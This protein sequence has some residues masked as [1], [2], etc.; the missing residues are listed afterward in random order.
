ALGF[1]AFGQFAILLVFGPRHAMSDGSLA[2]LAIIAFLRIARTEPH[3]SQLLQTQQTAHLA[4]ANQ[5]PAIG[6]AISTLLALWFGTVESVFAGAIIGEAL[7]L[8][9]ICALSRGALGEAFPVFL[10]WLAAGFTAAAIPAGLI[11]VTR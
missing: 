9:A 6:V 11:I 5:A 3:T 1:L 10:R 7:A 4:A 2:L 8:A